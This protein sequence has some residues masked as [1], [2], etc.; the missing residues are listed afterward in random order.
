MSV[1]PMN[2]HYSMTNP[3]SIYDEE[4]MTALELAGRT[5]GKV[6]ECVRYLNENVEKI[7]E[8]IQ[9][10]VKR[11]IDNGDFDAAI[12]A[13]LGYLKQRM[14]NLEE[15]FVDGSTTADAALFDLKVDVDGRTHNT[16][17]EAVRANQKKHIVYL[18]GGDLNDLH[19]QNMCCVVE[20]NTANIPENRSG[21]VDIQT[22]NTHAT[23]NPRTV[24]TW[25]GNH[26]IGNTYS[27]FYY[28]GTWSSWRRVNVGYVKEGF[29]FIQADG[30][31][32]DCID[33]FYGVA[34]GTAGNAPENDTALLEVQRYATNNN[35]TTFWV[36]QTWTSLNTGHVFHRS[37]NNQ[38]AWTMWRD[39]NSARSFAH[40]L[41]GKNIVFLGD[42]IFG[43]VRDSTGVVS[44][45]AAITGANCVN[46]AFGG[47]RAAVRPYAEYATTWA[48]MDGE[49]LVKAIATRDFSGQDA[50][51][52][53][54]S[55]FPSYF[56][57]TL[58]ELKNYDF[59]KADYVVMNWGTNDWTGHVS[60]NAYKSAIEN[61]VVM[62]L[63][64]YPNLTIIKVKPTNRFFAIDGAIIDAATH[65]YDRP[66]GVTLSEFIKA[67]D[68]LFDDYKI[69]VIDAFHIGINQINALGFFDS[70]DLTHHNAK[71]R[72]RLARFLSGAI[73]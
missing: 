60:S 11:H 48:Q 50:A 67:D 53:T 32:N 40:T 6:N 22:Y 58:T 73:M 41:H 72:E 69:Q 12:D 19:G 47:T 31:L 51:V 36:L 52:A 43:N 21:L 28:N 35:L 30:N 34:L 57:N 29:G 5:V 16:P 20:S 37:R 42:S 44:K 45:I 71:G 64:A 13:Y 24:Q 54:P 18:S 55:I 39:E 70:G 65:D 2:E 3:A 15:S 27:R 38:G 33:S 1:K 63:T 66:D 10:E 26:E 25:R 4:A 56:K 17:G 9:T 8:G 68:A 23:A 14:T 46:F 7:P 49:N 59:T 62:L 61:I